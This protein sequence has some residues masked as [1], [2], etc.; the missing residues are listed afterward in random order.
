MG[1]I[2]ISL[3]LLG[4]LLLS[5]LALTVVL[6][7]S[8]SVLH[9][10][11]VDGRVT[12]LH[13]VLEGAQSM[14]QGLQTGPVKAG[15][16]TAEEAQRRWLDAVSAVRFD[17]GTGYLFVL[18]RSGK[19]LAHG[20]NPA[21]VGTDMSGLKDQKGNLY[22]KDM[23]AVVRDAGQGRVDYWFPKVKG[24]EDLRKISYVAT[25]PGWNYLIGAGVYVDD[26]EAHFAMVRN[27][28]VAFAAAVMAAL[29][30]LALFISR[31]ITRSVG[32][33][34]VDLGKIAGG[35]PNTPV[36]GQDRKDEIGELARGIEG[37]RSAVIRAFELKQMVDE[38][39]A[40]VMI[41]EPKDL[42]V[43]YI[44]SSA[45]ALLR[46]VEDAIGC[47]AEEVLGR[48]I[49]SF[50]QRSEFLDRMLRDPSKLPYK[51]KFT[52]GGLVIENTVIPI[53]DQ[54]GAYVGPMLNW[55][56]VTKYVQMADQFQHKVQDVAGAV[57]VAA[58]EL[59]QLSGMLQDTAQE[60][61]TRSTSV[62]SAAE[63]AGANVQ[64]V[65]SAAE[66]LTASISE[67]AQRIEE[68]SV[69]SAQAVTRVEG[70]QDAI[71]SLN[72]SAVSIGEVVSLINDI[73]SQT[74]LLALNATIEAARA[75]E[76]GK[77][78]AVVANEVKSLATQTSRAT[79]DISRQIQAV[80]MATRATVE[81]TSEIRRAIDQVNTVAV[82]VASAIEEQSAATQEISRNVQQASQGTTQ[83]SDDIT[84]VVT[85]ADNAQSASKQVHAAALTLTDRANDL[86][87]EVGSFL[88]YI[89]KN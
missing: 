30:V 22:V 55:E 64:T 17:G 54:E 52:L 41:C 66:E 51:G 37:L 53:F 40:K 36:S 14:A 87:K 68:A 15:T 3:K 49:T 57:T 48:P 35:H 69:L 65:A 71:S 61:G 28:L 25:V 6:W 70:A 7:R 34:V 47:K 16:L 67:I 75:G 72:Q 39:P 76:A 18:D 46:Q 9:D 85:V 8:L 29:V 19:A 12:M 31:D 89:R 78:F 2:R 58:R 62:A 23:L 63:Q 81:A 86:S 83:V 84:H 4:V 20:Q 32:R 80:Q 60:V 5:A 33:L 79:E 38:Q 42:R 82:T 44:N 74:N 11:L 59:E 10:D 43:T 26:L 45:L 50:H 56:D 73:A 1:R 88:D 13:N 24:G 21:L 27:T 77:G